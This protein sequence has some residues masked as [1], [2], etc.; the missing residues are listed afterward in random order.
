[1]YVIPVTKKTKGHTKQLSYVMPVPLVKNFDTRC[2]TRCVQN[3]TK[4]NQKIPIG[5]FCNCTFN[6]RYK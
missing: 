5:H 2:S 4:Y 3:W 6:L 1:M